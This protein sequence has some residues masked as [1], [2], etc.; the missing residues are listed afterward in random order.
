[1]NSEE[2][3]SYQENQKRNKSKK[4]Y[5]PPRLI[6]YGDLK[7]ITKSGVPIG[8]DGSLHQPS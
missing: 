6:K 5:Q 4:E 1:M 8:A 2:S 3:I 7:K